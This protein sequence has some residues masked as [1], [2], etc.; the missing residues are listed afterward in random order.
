MTSIS[1]APQNPLPFNGARSRK[2]PGGRVIRWL[3]ANLFASVTSSVISLLLIVL[4][5]AVPARAADVDGKWT[6]S[7]ATPNGDVNV[8]FEF[9]SDGATL[10]GTTGA[11]TVARIRFQTGLAVAPPAMT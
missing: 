11:R 7:L 3:R 10:T 4:L 9:K 5:Y 8:G 6:G 1:D 2:V